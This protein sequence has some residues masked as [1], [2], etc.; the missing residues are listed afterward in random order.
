VHLVSTWAYGGD[1]RKGANADGSADL[2]VALLSAAKSKDLQ[3]SFRFVMDTKWDLCCSSMCV[4]VCMLLLLFVVVLLVEFHQECKWPR[5]AVK[6]GEST[7]VFPH[8]KGSLDLG[9]LFEKAQL[10][11]EV[12]QALEKDLR[13]LLKIPEDARHWIVRLETLFQEL[14]GAQNVLVCSFLKQ[15]ELWL[16]TQLEATATWYL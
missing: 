11:Y 9:A 1:Q 12:A 10:G 13:L 16:A 6:Y 3:H 4:R 2:F 8:Q 15:L 14:V 7:V 5:P